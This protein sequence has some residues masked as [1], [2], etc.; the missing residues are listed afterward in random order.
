MRY[1][2]LMGEEFVSGQAVEPG[3]GEGG[4]GGSETGGLPTEDHV[5]IESTL[6]ALPEVMFHAHDSGEIATY[7]PS[8]TRAQLRRVLAEMRDAEGRLRVIDP[9]GAL[10]VENRALVL[11]KALQQAS[12]IYVQKVG[13][14]S[15]PLE[16]ESRRLTGE[17]DEIRTRW[18]E[19]EPPA[20]P[21]TERAAR[22]LL[23]SLDDPGAA[24]TDSLEGLLSDPQMSVL[25]APIARLAARQPEAA[26]A[27]AAL[28]DLVAGRPP[29]A[30]ALE[31]REQTLWSLLPAPEPAPLAPLGSDD[32]L[33]RRYRESRAEDPEGENGPRENGSG[34]DGR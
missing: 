2:A 6:E 15:P 16:P 24:G 22:R 11:H 13:F 8:E 20:A 10:P 30:A 33:S 12:R 34:E 21:E 32:A 18:E 31:R 17:L 1:G 27:L 26:E 5:S 7:F 3:A 9:P 4:A 19:V 28:D 14:E 25:R 23:A 29:A